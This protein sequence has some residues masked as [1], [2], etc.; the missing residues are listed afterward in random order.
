M[1][2]RE[3]STRLVGVRHLRAV[4]RERQ[5]AAARV[6]QRGLP[7]GP[8]A[9]RRVARQVNSND[10][11]AAQRRRQRHRLQRRRAVCMRSVHA[12]SRAHAC[13][14]RCADAGVPSRRS[15]D[16]MRRTVMRPRPSPP[17]G[18]HGAAS[19]PARHALLSAPAAERRGTATRLVALPPRT[20]A[21]SSQQ[22]RSPVAEMQVSA[23]RAARCA[24]WCTCALCA[25]A[26]GVVRSSR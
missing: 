23:L 2:V 5:A 6:R 1:R 20:T 16:R 8:G 12:E 24:Q 15:I 7:G 18:P 14:R 26:F 3:R 25:R 9:Q 10:A 13:K 4:Q 11:A 17:P 21:L 22:P 19:M